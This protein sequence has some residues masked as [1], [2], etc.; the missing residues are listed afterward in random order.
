MTALYLGIDGTNWIHQ[1]WHAMSASK[2]DQVLDAAMRRL[3]AIVNWVESPDRKPRLECSQVLVCFDR[4]SFRAD[5]SPCY[6]GTRPPKP[7][8]LIETLA[9]AEPAFDRQATSAAVDGYEAD[10]LL[11]TLAQV[12][13]QSGAQ[14]ILASP[15]KDLRQC[16]RSGQ[17]SILAS[18]SV[19]RGVMVSPDWWK[20]SRLQEDYGLRPEQW[21]DYQALVGEKGDNVE[22][23]ASVGPKTAAAMLEQCGS[24]PEILRNPWAAPCTDRQRTALFAWR[25]KAQ[26][27]MHL[28]TL[29][30]DVV[31]LY[32]YLR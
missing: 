7:Q 32:D 24:L 26:L 30:R 29:R 12:A 8:G 3:A 14:C 17:V 5:L 22:G 10:D 4:R 23:C 15:D 20:A 25:P 21:A 28:V 19:Q 11:A 2:P 27:A 16:L 9:K 18:C 1:L 13:V 31:E 6:K